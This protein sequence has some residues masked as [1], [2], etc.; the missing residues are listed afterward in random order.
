MPGKAEGE[1][2]E[3]TVSTI[4]SLAS[5]GTVSM[6]PAT[7]TSS[8]ASQSAGTS[9]ELQATTFEAGKEASPPW[10]AAASTTGRPTTTELFNCADDFMN[11]KLGWSVAKRE[12]CCRF[13]SRGCTPTAHTPV[14]TSGASEPCTTSACN[15]RLSSQQSQ[16]GITGD[17][18]VIGD[19]EITGDEICEGHAFSEK[20]CMSIGCCF[21]DRSS[22]ICYS[23]VANRACLSAKK[24]ARAS[25]P[26][27]QRAEVIRAPVPIVV[28]A[29][30]PVVAKSRT[31]HLASTT[32]TTELPDLL[33]P[34]KIKVTPLLLVIVGF[35][36][37]LSFALVTSCVGCLV[38][39]CSRPKPPKP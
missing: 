25:A 39:Y 27:V 6:T 29:P 4:V 20:A 37:L 13:K 11:W 38:W 31:A 21:F 5:G 24:A 10:P 19:A 18:E 23:A 2:E 17:G 8:T 34:I 32:T 30:R 15:E 36:A 22:S 28:Q 1:S 16:R 9:K 35:S 12:W 3:D 26:G 7:S 33:K 14:N